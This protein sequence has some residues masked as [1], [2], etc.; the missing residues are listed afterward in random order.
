MAFMAQP[1]K[2]PSGIYY[3]RRRIPDDIK[4]ILGRGDF[5]KV[6][7]QTR[8]PAEAKTRFAAEWRKADQLFDTARLQLRIG[9]QLTAKDAVQLAARWAHR[10]L[11]E[12]EQSGVYSSWLVTHSGGAF[13]T[14]GSF[15]GSGHS[16]PTFLAASGIQ[17]RLLSDIE[18]ELARY[19]RPLVPVDSVAYR[20]LLE[21]F[22]AQLLRLSEAALDRSHHDH[23]TPLQA[24]PPAPLSFEAPLNKA[25]LLSHF[26]EDWKTYVL[27]VGSNG[28]DV[29]KRVTEYGGTIKVFIE[30]N[31]DLPINAITRT[32]ASTFA[33]DLLKMPTGGAGRRALNA[34]QLIAKAEADGMPTLGHLTVKNRLMAL[35]A[36]LS[37]AVRLGMLT[38]NA[39]T[40]SGVTGELS[41]AAKKAGRTTARKHYTRQELKQIFSSPVF[42]RAWTPPRATFGEAWYWI[43]LL[44]YYTGAR[45]EEVAQMK[46]GEVQRSEDGVWFLDLLSTPDDDAPEEKRT[47]K[48]AGSRRKVPLHPDLV[49]LG[50]LKYAADVPAKGQL[51]P[52]LE[53]NPS[54][55]YSVNFGKRW[56]EYLK[57]VAHVNSKVRPSH[58]FRHTF[59]TLCREQ[60]VPE[61]LRDALTG[62]DNGAVS[63]KYGERALL[64]QL[65]EQMEKLPSI[66]R[67]AG[68]LPPLVA[69]P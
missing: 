12:M 40:A 36:V 6:S 11:H 3:I 37:H 17:S 56:S 32:T 15:Y 19:N 26:F 1:W 59:I 62:H 51:F 39:V 7:L 63:R 49:A 64:P 22:A 57:K 53:A 18:Q 42:H 4:S 9:V 47:V 43:P 52:L 30:L 8:V 34:R 58:G 20:H 60:G 45:R 35:S 66:A 67:E 69:A 14:L 44:L 54:G 13:E 27:K 5:Y 38:E 25:P 24:P 28:R 2:H 41:K 10:E 61:E 29:T 33:T 68:L 21:A 31:G 48:T 46:A 65:L 55:Y 23:V 50:F 16:V